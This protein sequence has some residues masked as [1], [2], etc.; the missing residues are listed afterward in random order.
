MEWGLD[1]LFALI[2]IVLV[3]EGLMPAMMP[4]TWRKLLF[5]FASY[6]DNTIRMMGLSSMVLGAILITVVHNWDSLTGAD[7][8]FLSSLF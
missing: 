3:I 5:K 8:S 4:D 6:N 2:A 1:E 7:P